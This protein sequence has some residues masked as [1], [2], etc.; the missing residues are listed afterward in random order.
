MR[1]YLLRNTF[2][3]VLLIGVLDFVATKLHLYWTVWWFDMLM[4]FIAGLCA[5]MGFIYIWNKFIRRITWNKS[6]IIFVGLLGTLFIGVIWEFYE[7]Y[8]GISFLYEGDNFWNDTLSDL[9]LDMLGGYLG[10]L[11]AV[12]LL[13]KE[14]ILI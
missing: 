2:F 13:K 7:I 1:N 9:F 8:F 12:R 3:L 10:A 11:Y 6:K 14:Q 5:S 4:H